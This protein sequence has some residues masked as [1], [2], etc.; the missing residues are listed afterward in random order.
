MPKKYNLMFHDLIFH[1]RLKHKIYY[2]SIKYCRNGYINYKTKKDNV[3][4]PT[5]IM[6]IVHTPFNG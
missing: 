4:F 3:K 6:W 2:T 1:K 5:V